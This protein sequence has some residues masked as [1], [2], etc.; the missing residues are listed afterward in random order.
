MSEELSH[1]ITELANTMKLK[2][3]LQ[4]YEIEF[5]N[6]DEIERYI[7]LRIHGERLQKLWHGTWKNVFKTPEGG[8]NKDDMPNPC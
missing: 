6:L 1:A 4:V 2:T 5:C 7:G 3:L 8:D